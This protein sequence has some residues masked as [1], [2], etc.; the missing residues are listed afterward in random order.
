M[1]CHPQ[2]AQNEELDPGVRSYDNMKQQKV[3]G[4]IKSNNCDG[5][6]LIGQASSVPQ[7]SLP[8]ESPQGVTP[9]EPLLVSQKKIKQREKRLYVG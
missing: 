7:C 3:R 9:E 1:G 5:S 8:P 6:S 2:N 4:L